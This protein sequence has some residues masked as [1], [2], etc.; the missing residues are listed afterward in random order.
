MAWAYVALAAYQLYASEQ[1][2]GAIRDNAEEQRRINEL[3]AMQFEIDAMEAEKYGF[4]DAARYETR[5][6]DTIGQQKVGYAAQNVDVSSGTAAQAI[7]ESRVAGDLNKMDQV[8]RGREKARGLRR[9]A[10][11]VRMGS[12]A[13][14][15]QAERDAQSTIRTG[16]INAANTGLTGYEKNKTSGNSGSSNKS[17]SDSYRY[18]D[19]FI[20]STEE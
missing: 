16:Y 15:A 8:R 11:N 2:A 4:T 10:I 3:S 19:L 13:R 20:D 18:G 12:Q 9:D 5:I 6:S 14:S 1:Q 17:K 7:E